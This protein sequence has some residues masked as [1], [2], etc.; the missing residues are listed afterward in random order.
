M[1]MK[2]EAFQ[3]TEAVVQQ[4]YDG[5]QFTPERLPQLAPF[6]LVTT[7]VPWQFGQLRR[8]KQL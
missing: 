2:D 3:L 4:I 6:A 1:E 7:F 5:P 8:F